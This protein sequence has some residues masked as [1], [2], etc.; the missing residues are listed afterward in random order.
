MF[1]LGLMPLNKQVRLC[2][3]VISAET[4]GYLGASCAEGKSGIEES[5]AVGTLNELA[6]DA[7]VAPEPIKKAAQQALQDLGDSSCRPAHA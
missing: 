4:L 3:Q 6:G 1:N 7:S 2:V 5:G